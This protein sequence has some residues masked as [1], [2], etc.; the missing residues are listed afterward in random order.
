MKKLKNRINFLDA[1]AFEIIF[2]LEKQLFI[3]K[4]RIKNY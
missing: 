4:K 1:Q 2:C 3:I